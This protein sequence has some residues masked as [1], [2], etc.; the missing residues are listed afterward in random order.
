[1]KKLILATL[2]TLTLGLT[3]NAFAGYGLADGLGLGFGSWWAEGDAAP[4]GQGA[5][6]CPYGCEP[7]QGLGLGLGYGDGTAPMPM[8]GTGFGSP[9]TR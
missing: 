2:L 1:M 8:D 4:G 9:F 6:V 5:G 7:G 3:T